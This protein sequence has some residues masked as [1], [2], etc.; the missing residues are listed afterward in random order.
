MK[1][2]AKKV[3]GIDVTK[4]GNKSQKT[5]AKGRQEYI[6]SKPSSP[7]SPANHG[8]NSSGQKQ[9]HIVKMEEKIGRRLRE[10]EAVQHK[11]DNKSDNRL[12]NLSL[13][14]RAK[15]TAKSNKMRAKY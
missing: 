9:T 13:S 3:I 12:S 14:T 15:N 2:T 7:K 4:A 5:M 8:L 10:G 6:F 11:N 1:S